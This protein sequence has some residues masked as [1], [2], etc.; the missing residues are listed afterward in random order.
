MGYQI[1]R[2]TAKYVGPRLCE[3][4]SARVAVE[5]PRVSASSC[6]EINVARE[7]F[8]LNL[9]QLQEV[10]SSFSTSAIRDQ[11]I[12]RTLSSLPRL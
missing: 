8:T 12:A 11:E 1:L 10:S 2:P 7:N 9:P 6:G 4:Q 3:R 5:S